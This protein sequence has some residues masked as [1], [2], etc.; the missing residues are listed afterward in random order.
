MHKG[1]CRSSRA[2]R[3][4]FLLITEGPVHA[5][6]RL[7]RA[8]MLAHP[9]RPCDACGA[10]DVLPISSN[11]ST[12]TLRPEPVHEAVPGSR[13]VSPR[14]IF[15]ACETLGVLG[16][17]GI[18]ASR[19][20]PSSS[21]GSPRP[22][23]ASDRALRR[24]AVEQSVSPHAG[25]AP[26][27]AKSCSRIRLNALDPRRSTIRQAMREPL[28]FLGLSGPGDRAKPR[29]CAR[30]RRARPRLHLPDRYPHQLSG[31]QPPARLHRTRL[32]SPSR[33]SW[34]PTRSSRRLTPPCR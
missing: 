21:S 15:G 34:L 10:Q 14:R 18:P 23:P 31:G 11:V 9:F 26:T 28:E 29:G 8:S 17:L 32:C 27:A 2:R 20:S 30:R 7:H 4:R 6:A 12:T 3:A 1:Q 5:C 19:P 25:A 16:E 24:D 22:T 33:I 13:T